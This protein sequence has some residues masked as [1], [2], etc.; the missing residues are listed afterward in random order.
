MRG[1]ILEVESALRTSTRVEDISTF[2]LS[3]MS[4]PNSETLSL[5]Q[6]CVNRFSSG[7]AAVSTGK[8][9]VFQAFDTCVIAQ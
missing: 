8:I 7:A 6:R 3:A 4:L 2:F 1:T 9:P 5:E